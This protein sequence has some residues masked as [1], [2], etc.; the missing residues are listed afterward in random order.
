MKRI[1]LV[2]ALAAILVFPVFAQLRLDVGID[3]PFGI[4]VVG[5]GEI[6]EDNDF[7]DFLAARSFFAVPEVSLY[8]QFGEGSVKFAPGLRAFSFLVETVLWP[9]LMMEIAL[10]PVYIQAQFGGLLFVL[11]GLA[12][13]TETGKVF[14]PDLSV[15]VGL[16]KERRFR[17]GA[18]VIGLLL[19]DLTTKGIVYAPYIGGKVS[20]L[21]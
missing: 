12:S 21:F 3:A 19:P 14:F 13:G 11:L 15:W 16:G 10:D 5:S 2:A 7:G 20:L 4:G 6:E 1:A 8:Y 9:N 17:L 18:G